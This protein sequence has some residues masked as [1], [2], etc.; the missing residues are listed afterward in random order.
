MASVTIHNAAGA[1]VGNVELADSVFGLSPN[2]SAMHQTVVAQLAAR[3]AGTQSTKTRGEVRGGGRKPFK[4]KGTGSARQGSTR[5]AQWVGGG[6]A[7]GPKPR[8]Y[9]QKVNKKVI[10]LALRSALSDRASLGKIAVVDSWEMAEPSTK[11]AIAALKALGIE[12]RVLIVMTT[13]DINAWKSYRNLTKVQCI[14]VAELNT[15][16]V[17]CNE[18]IVF[19]KETLPQG[20]HTPMAAASE[21]PVAISSAVV[22]VSSAKAAEEA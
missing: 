8:K 6:V 12:N 9:D 22:A 3:R 15:Y 4:Q 13:D 11:Q 18:W 17:L 21:T 2:S 5:A 10:K 14:D 1:S 19:S 16:D 7:L 20:D